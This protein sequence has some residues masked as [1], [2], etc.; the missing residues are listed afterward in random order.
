[1]TWNCILCISGCVFKLLLGT[2][3]END[4]QWSSLQVHNILLGTVYPIDNSRWEQCLSDLK[5]F[6]FSFVNKVRF[7]NWVRRNRRSM[8]TKYKQRRKKKRRPEL[9]IR[10]PKRPFRGSWRTTRRWHLPPDTSK[11]CS[12]LAMVC[13]LHWF[14]VHWIV[15]MIMSSL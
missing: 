7:P 15:N 14:V 9:N 2:G 6:V 3:Y 13:S 5:F 8:P 12:D 4:Y 10:S 11:S 1:M